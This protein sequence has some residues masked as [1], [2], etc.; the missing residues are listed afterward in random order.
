MNISAYLQYLLSKVTRKFY[1]AFI[2]YVCAILTFFLQVF[3]NMKGEC[4]FDNIILYYVT[5]KIRK[6]CSAISSNQSVCQSSSL[7]SKIIYFP[8][9]I[10]SVR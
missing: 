1:K 6:I 3:C 5:D 7:N 2:I 9:H 8:N 4:L 10:W